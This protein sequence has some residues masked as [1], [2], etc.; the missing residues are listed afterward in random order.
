[1]IP[2]TTIVWTSLVIQIITAHPLLAPIPLANSVALIDDKEAVNTGQTET[3]QTGTG[4]VGTSQMGTSQIETGQTGTGQTGTGQTGTSQTGTS[5]TGTGQ[6][7]AIQSGT[8]QTGTGQTGTGQIGTGQMDQLAGQLAGQQQS[9][10]T[11]PASGDTSDYIS[12]VNKWRSS[13]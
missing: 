4:Q 9:N 11:Q 3:S 7:E 8:G 13:E 2:L 6:T 5:Q 12:V 1:M 10:N